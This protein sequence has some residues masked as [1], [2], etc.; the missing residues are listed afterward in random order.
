MAD[1][2]LLTIGAFARAVELTPSALRYYDDCGLLAPAEVDAA[3]GYRYDTPELASRARL[4]RSMRDVGVPVETMRQVLDGPSD[5]VRAALGRFVSERTDQAARAAAV[6][7]DVLA[8]LERADEAGRPVSA[9]VDGPE[10][11][12]ALAQVRH[13]TDTDGTSPL[14]CVLVELDGDRVEVVATNRHWMALR[15]LV[16]PALAGRRTGAPARAVLPPAS[17]TQRVR[18]L[19]GSAD[20]AVVLADGGLRVEEPGDEPGEE[21]PTRD[22][23]WP[24]HRLVVAGLDEP[25]CRVTLD[26][27]ALLDTLRAAD[28]AVVSVTVDAPGSAVT[29]RGAG[30]DGVRLAAGVRGEGL[31][32][33]LS[34]A[35]WSRATETCVGPEVTLDLRG[36]L[37]PVTVRSAYQPSFQALVMPTSAEE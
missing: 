32:L 34:T 22:V 14:A 10:L 4:I 36:P 6:V 31:R 28:R 27:D 8:E 20:V 7:A 37:L 33:L 29:V 24:A 18:L 11:A 23:P 19:A 25:V 17:V 9:V 3:T 2:V 35:L 13:A 26:R 1:D 30:Q 12:A 21:I 16:V 15:T 5:D